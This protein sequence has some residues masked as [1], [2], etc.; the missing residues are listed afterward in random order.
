[1][2]DFL[3]EEPQLKNNELRSNTSEDPYLSPQVLANDIIT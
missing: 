1:M 3:Q 2:Y